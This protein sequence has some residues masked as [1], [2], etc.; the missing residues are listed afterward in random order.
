MPPARLRSSFDADGWA[1]SLALPMG[2]TK[3]GNL[4]ERQ[5]AEMTMDGAIAA[6][7][8]HRVGLVG[9]VKLVAGKKIHARQF[10]GPD[11]V[12]FGVRSQQGNGA[13]G[14][15]FA[16]AAGKTKCVEIG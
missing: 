12:L 15:S 14:A 1:K 2:T 3:R 4:L 7:N 11:V 10:K 8:Q 6:K 9:G 5:S 13:H 16:Y